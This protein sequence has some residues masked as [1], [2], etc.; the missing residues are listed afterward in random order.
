MQRRHGMKLELTIR[1]LRYWGEEMWLWPD[2]ADPNHQEPSHLRGEIRAASH[3]SD[4]RV[5]L[6]IIA[7]IIASWQPEPFTM[8][9]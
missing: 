7:S 5:T 3:A 1:E 9:R 8:A 2:T 6:S 4:A